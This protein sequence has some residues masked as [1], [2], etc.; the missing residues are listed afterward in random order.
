M[1]QQDSH[2]NEER[3][4]PWSLGS[5]ISSL[6]CDQALFDIKDFAVVKNDT[7]SKITK[8]DIPETRIKN[9]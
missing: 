4:P 3:M 7:S 5:E 6:G 9:T 8:N 2:F 1:N